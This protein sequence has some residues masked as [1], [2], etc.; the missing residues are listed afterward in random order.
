MNIGKFLHFSTMN[1][2]IHHFS[3]MNLLAIG[4]A[5][6][7]GA[8]RGARGRVKAGGDGGGARETR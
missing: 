2:H 7:G 1:L 3:T 4:T 8:G 6:A 5:A